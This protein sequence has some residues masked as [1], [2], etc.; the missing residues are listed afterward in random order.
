V[1]VCRDHPPLLRI[2]KCSDN[3]FELR[4]GTQPMAMPISDRIFNKLS[5]YAR[6]LGITTGHTID[7]FEAPKEDVLI[8]ER[9]LTPMHRAFY[10]NTG[11]TVHK[12][13]PYLDAYHSHLARY[14][15]TPVRV[16]EIG[17]YRGGSLQMW[18]KYFG[19]QAI[20]FGVDIDP[21]CR[22]Y[23]GVA[24]RVRIGSQEDD[25]FL[26]GVVNEMGGLDVVIDDG[27]HV[28]SHQK[29]SF[30]ALFPL[31]SVDGTYICE[32]TITSYFRGYFEGGFRRKNSIIEI[33][34]RI[35][36]DLNADFH[37]HKQSL[38]RANRIIKGVHFYFGMIV[39]EKACNPPPRHIKVPPE[40][41][42][43]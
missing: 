34:K 9:Q 39:I 18:R 10:E 11:T 15:N 1:R 3:Q 36:D 17:V 32:D 8:S 23:D 37:R 27:S 29:A 19:E 30:E 16:L 22:Q 13:Q 31:L 21:G 42:I 41:P 38:Q 14:R 40:N 26:R 33:A 20:I 35:V 28:A 7:G 43:V 2:T 5:I 4:A 12:W 6:K 25:A 24:G